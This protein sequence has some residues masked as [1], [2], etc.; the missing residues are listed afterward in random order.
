MAAPTSHTQNTTVCTLQRYCNKSAKY[1]VL[2]RTSNIAKRKK[3]QQ[4]RADYRR[5]CLHALAKIKF[6]VSS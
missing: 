1:R 6:T 2:L 3:L 4:G 5:V